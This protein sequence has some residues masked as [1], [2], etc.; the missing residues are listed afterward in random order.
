MKYIKTNEGFF[1]FFKKE[2]ENIIS[3][4]SEDD[5]KS[6]FYELI[7]DIDLEIH[8]IPVLYSKRPLHSIQYQSGTVVENDKEDRFIYQGPKI[9]DKYNAYFFL[10]SGKDRLN[11]I[12]NN[13]RKDDN[14]YRLIE[15]LANQKSKS[16]DIN[17]KIFSVYGMLPNFYT[18]LLY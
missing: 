8:P 11:C 9:Q 12:N 6:M 18:I 1:N 10:I 2:K 5:I 3:R 15:N 16:Y 7:D 17:Y 14:L 4:F 13:F